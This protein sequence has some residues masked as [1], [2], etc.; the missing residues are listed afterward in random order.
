MAVA[1]EEAMVVAVAARHLQV[2]PQPAGARREHEDE[3]LRRRGVGA[4]RRW[5]RRRRRWGCLVCVVAVGVAAGGRRHLRPRL[6]E[7]VHLLVAR[8]SRRRAVDPAVL[9]LAV[10]AV[11]LEDV[12]HPRH[13]REDEDAVALRL[14]AA[15]ELVEEHH[16]PRVLDEALVG[17]ERRLLGALEEVRVVG[18]P[19][20]IWGMRGVSS[21]GSRAT[22]SAPSKRYGWLAHL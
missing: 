15:E 9:E 21:C 18:A 2:D 8:L 20:G 1:E 5:R 11:V 7:G 10:A 3:D 13:L 6:V 12:E 17:G 14:E 4:V 22:P 19:V 16:L